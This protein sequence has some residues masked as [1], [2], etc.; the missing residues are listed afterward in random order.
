MSDAEKPITAEWCREHGAKVHKHEFTRDGKNY[1]GACWIV[2]SVV[3][4]V[5]GGEHFSVNGRPVSRRL[6]RSELLAI[7]TALKGGAT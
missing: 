5:Y 3:I 4:A 2:A 6:S 7:V 1:W